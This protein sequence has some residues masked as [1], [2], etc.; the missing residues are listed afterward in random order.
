MLSRVKLISEPWDLGPGGYQLG[1]IPP[2]WPNGTTASATACAASGAATRA[3]A[4]DFAAR[5]A[6]S[7]DV[8]EH[9]GA[10]ALGL[11][12]YVAATTASPCATW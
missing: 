4:R 3:S 9:R 5:L 11:V 12:N 2:G 6:A 8:F 7:S 1:S 10:P